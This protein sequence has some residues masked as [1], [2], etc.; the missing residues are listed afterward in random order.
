[1]TSLV[2]IQTRVAGI[3]CQIGVESYFHQRPDRGSWE[4]DWDYHGYTQTDWL[5]LDR[6]GR[7]AP[8][9]ERK[10]T[11]RDKD[12]IESE[13]DAYFREQKQAAP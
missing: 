8:W 3:P 11:E 7:P 2:Q 13:I 1:V 10:M 5:I 4:S 12:R 9:L 6:Q